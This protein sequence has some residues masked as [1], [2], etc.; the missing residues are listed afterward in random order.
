MNSYSP[1][2]FTYSKLLGEGA[3]GKVRK[4][5]HESPGAKDTASATSTNYDTNSSYSKDALGTS[6]Y[7]KMTAVTPKQEDSKSEEA[8]PK[9]EM[10]V[11]LQS[12]Y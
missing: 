9:K 7:F 12:K 1:S 2:E 4:C 8:S 11:K 3:Y 10:A 6:P 5:L